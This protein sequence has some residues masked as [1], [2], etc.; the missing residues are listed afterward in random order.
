MNISIGQFGCKDI[1]LQNDQ[2]TCQVPRMDPGKLAVNVS[3]FFISN[4]RK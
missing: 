1:I 2:I 3:S 4:T